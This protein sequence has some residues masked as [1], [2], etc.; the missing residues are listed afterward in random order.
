[1]S[2][3][4]T[5]GIDYTSRDYEAYRELMIQK[6]QEKMPEYTDV[7]QTDAGIV[8]LECLA[9]G[10][11]ILSM[12]SDIVANDVLLPTTQDRRMA[13]ILARN[14]GYTPYNQTASITP[15]VFVLNSVKTEPFVIPKG[16]VVTTEEDD[17]ED[18][19]EFETIESLI[20]PAGCLGNEQDED[21]NY[22]Y[23][24][25]VVQGSSVTEDLIGSSTGTPYQSFMLNFSEVIPDTIILLV[26]EGDGYYEWEQVDS[27]LS[28]DINSE[29]MVYTVTVDE[30]DRCYIEFGNGIYGKI[31]SAYPNG[32]IAS[33]KIGGGTGGNVQA[34]TI[35]V[36]DSSIPQ[37]DTTFNPLG[38]TTLAH[39]KETIEEIKCN[40]PASFKTRDRAVILSDYS[41]LIRINNRGNMYG[42]RDTK[43]LRDEKDGMKVNLYYQMKTDYV[44]TEELKEEILNFFIP[45][46]TMIG[47]KLEIFPYVPYEIDLV[48]NLIVDKDYVQT[49]IEN[50][51]R[52]YV[53][54]SFFYD[55]AFTFEDEFLKSEL[56]NE[57][58]ETI[59]GVRSFRISSPLEDLIVAD[60]SHKII[61][62]RDLTINST[63]GKV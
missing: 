21:G 42:I 63:G 31:P 19:I 53:R 36:L 26:N 62:L 48:A 20:I 6:L 16:T 61:T 18:V 1:M 60:E 59:D 39:D 35:T 47:T 38:S 46:R 34:N 8:I 13:C 58:L 27:F 17:E 32:I 33:Y 11:D 25:N 57:V 37:V 50:E 52:E 56:E 40:A 24:V 43:A 30:F 14:L 28:K 45:R 3:V 12:Y 4:P 5:Q 23:T 15:Q 49:E 10:L 54:G 55:G 9:N 2:R 44:M 41:D 7:S 29:S 22:L 51:V